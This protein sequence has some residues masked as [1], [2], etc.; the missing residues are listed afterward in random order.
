MLDHHGALGPFLREDEQLGDAH[1][2]GGVDGD[3]RVGG[4]AR[5]RDDVDSL[6]RLPGQRARAVLR[7]S[8]EP[9]ALVGSERGFDRARRD[10]NLGLSRVERLKEGGEPLHRCEAPLL[11]FPGGNL[12]I[13]R[14]ERAEPVRPRRPRS[15]A[16]ALAFEDGFRMV[17]G[18]RVAH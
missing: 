12:E 2:F 6:G 18:Q 13:G 4:F 8:D 14:I 1:P 15:L 11:L 7:L 16:D 17:S 5:D 3:H 10:E 9:D